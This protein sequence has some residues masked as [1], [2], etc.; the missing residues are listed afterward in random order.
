MTM[1]SLLA[2][3][4]LNSCNNA[5]K[6]VH[7]IP[8]NYQGAVTIIFDC[9]E[10]SE[11]EYEGA[12]RVYR[13]GK[14][15]V[16]KLNAPFNKGLLKPEEQLFFYVDSLGNRTEVKHHKETH[17]SAETNDIM[18]FNLQF[19][20]N[21]FENGQELNSSAVQYLVCTEEKREEFYNKRINPCD[22]YC[23]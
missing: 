9:K 12:T 14:D 21:C 5:E 20:G 15:G 7:L 1:I 4:L 19:H 8:A 16:L 18:I 3:M 2:I 22:L 23:K 13:I 11:L 17:K 10:G 6:E